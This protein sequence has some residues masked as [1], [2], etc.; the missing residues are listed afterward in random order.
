MT[1]LRELTQSAKFWFPLL[2]LNISLH[3]ADSPDCSGSYTLYIKLCP[4]HY[5]TSA[6]EFVTRVEPVLNYRFPLIIT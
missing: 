2:G 4:M 5:S 3:I 6:E 1:L